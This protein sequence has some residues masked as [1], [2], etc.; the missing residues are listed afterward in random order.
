MAFALLLEICHYVGEH[1]ESVHAGEWTNNID[2]CY[3]KHPLIEL[4]DKTMGII[5]YG[6]IGRSVGAI[7]KAFGMKVVAYDAFVKAEESVSLDE[8]LAKSDVISLHCPLFPET[9]ASSARTTSQR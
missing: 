7:A 9:Q 5:G 2:W 3:W 8:L 4:A 1:S 6:R